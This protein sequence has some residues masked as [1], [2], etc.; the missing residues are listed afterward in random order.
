MKNFL[1]PG[2]SIVF[3]A[4]YD[5]KSGEGALLGSLFGVATID[6]LSTV[7]APFMTR[8]VFLLKKTASQSWAQGDAI[9]WDDT[10]KRCDNTS[11]VGPQIGIAELAAASGPSLTTGQVKLTPINAGLTS[12][13]IAAVGLQVRARFSAAQVNAGATLIAAVTGKKIRILDIIMIAV[14]G[15]GTTATSVDILGTQ[16]AG[17]VKLDSV[18]I[19]ALTQS[20]VNRMGATNNAVLADGASFAPN[21]VSTAVTIGKTGSSLAGAT[22]IDVI[23]EYALDS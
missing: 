20:T 19:A 8:G 7:S 5:R 12:A 10:N 16:S 6:V 15:A 14:G 21:D 4:P 18:A 3:A 22:S 17:S 1:H 13:A 23:C 2:D 11:T 9:Y